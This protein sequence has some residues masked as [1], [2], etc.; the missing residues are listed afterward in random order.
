MRDKSNLV[1]VTLHL[2]PAIKAELDYLVALHQAH[3]APNLKV[4]V[5]SLMEYVA[6]AVADGSRRPGAWERGLLESM[7]LVPDTEAAQVYRAKY[8]D[9][10]IHGKR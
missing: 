8:G 4:S 2:D 10:E 5:E 6:S 7:G 1:A 3:G 9:P